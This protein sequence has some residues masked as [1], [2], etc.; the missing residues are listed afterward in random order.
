M[1]KQ[2]TTNYDHYGTPVFY[3]GSDGASVTPSDTLTF[4]EGPL[5]VGSGGTIVVKT[6]SGTNLTFTNVNNGA[7]LP[8]I[9]TMVYSTGTTA[10]DINVLY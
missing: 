4:Q 6:V 2:E 5:Y 10:S 3:Q 8:V 1:Q 7:F 9:C